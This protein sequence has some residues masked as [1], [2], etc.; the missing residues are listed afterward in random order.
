M[1]RQRHV[2][3]KQLIEIELPAALDAR[4]V[5]TELSRIYRQRMI[6]LI[7]ETCSALV[8]PDEIVSIDRLEIDL[9]D[10]ELAQLEQELVSRFRQAL[11]E[12]LAQQ[13]SVQRAHA[14]KTGMDAPAA[15]QLELL[16]LFLRTGA[17]PWWADSAQLDLVPA[18]V[19]WLLQ[20]AP[21]QLRAMLAEL[22]TAL[23]TLQRLITNL[24]DARL[25]EVVVLLLP[26]ATPTTSR[27][28]R[29]LAET[30]ARQRLLGPLPAPVTHRRLWRAIWQA[31]MSTERGVAID[32]AAML[33]A[34]VAAMS[35][36]G[37]TADKL[38]SVLPAGSAL[39]DLIDRQAADDG[40]V[41]AARRLELERGG[42]ATA[43]G[44]TRRLAGDRR[45][46]PLGVRGR[47]DAVRR[48][49]PSKA[50]QRRPRK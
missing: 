9:G 37:L 15:S 23:P 20:S 19:D 12:A 42:A 38:R 3:K 10:L 35:T 49:G 34:T 33:R 40:T 13:L 28:L 8:G 18:A 17:V 45:A 24:D 5:Q 25:A 26:H 21:Q 41:G 4:A 46:G 50:G 48:P 44:A 14:R 29:E 39:A 27:W 2:I 1:S 32:D 22:L 7:E 16:A 11:P 30:V 31:V 36:V 43:A 47:A 6:P